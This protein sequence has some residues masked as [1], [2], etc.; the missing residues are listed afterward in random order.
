[1][2]DLVSVIVPV[3][4]AEK[5]LSECIESILKQSYFEIELL[6]VDDGS[7]DQSGA[8]CASYVEKDSRVRYI[9]KEN[10][11]VSSARNAGIDHAKGEYLFFCD[12][13]D[14]LAEDALQLCVEKMTPKTDL[15]VG[16]L[17][18]KV[19]EQSGILVDSKKNEKLLLITSDNWQGE[20][21]GDL[22][23]SSC[24]KLY[25]KKIV[26]DF[27]LRFH[28]NQK[29]LEDMKFVFDYLSVSNRWITLD[30][31]IYLYRV[32]VGLDY[33]EKRRSKTLDQDVYATYFSAKKYFSSKDKPVPT[34]VKNFFFFQFQMIV[35]CEF[36]S[37]H[38]K[39]AKKKKILELTEWILSEKLIEGMDRGGF[40]RA[41]QWLL[42]RKNYF[43]YRL[44]NRLMLIR[45]G[46]KVKGNVAIKE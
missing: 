46:S 24:A 12:S 22:F 45:Y 2:A 17:E 19:F 20:C 14:W 23:S 21:V 28:E 31:V 6:L 8:I 5:Y 27:D 16:W 30:K 36:W 11:G 29:M 37:N 10:G 3:F 38:S 41:E 43:M 40:T 35:K 15:V 9:K 7:T 13:D 42:Y 25:R 39:N 18:M 33:I 26:S 44:L 34:S 1:M 32:F 4:N